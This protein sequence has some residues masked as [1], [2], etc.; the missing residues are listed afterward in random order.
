MNKYMIIGSLICLY[1]SAC[2]GMNDNIEEYLNRGEVNYLGKVEQVLTVG[3]NKRIKISWLVNTDP[4]I[5]SCKIFWNNWSDSLSYPIDRNQLDSGRFSVILDNINEGMYVFNIHHEGTKGYQ[6]I[7]QEV[8]GDV[9]GER[10]QTSLNPRR[11]KEIITLKGLVEIN[12]KNA[13]ESF[14]SRFYYTNNKGV[15]AVLDIPASEMKTIITDCQFGGT[16]TYTTFYL[17][18][19]QALDTFSVD[20]APMSF[21]DY[22]LLD[23]TNWKVIDF[24]D[25]SGD[26]GGHTTVIDG[27]L[28]TFWHNAYEPSIPPPHHI[29]L[30]MQEEKTLNKIV[31]ARRQNNSDLKKMHLDVSSD[32]EH[33]TTIGELNFSNMPN[34]NSM[35]L[36][37]KTGVK[38]RYLKAIITDSH[39]EPYVSISEIYVEG[40]E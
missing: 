37:L 20:A 18:K 16:F 32:N 23:R 17:P 28:T 4:R 9:Y 7:N 5:E 30:D 27:S 26:G 40:L 6:S 21:P 13:E 2:G 29:T 8:V 22:Y 34:Q 25:E 33:W 12:W 24:S 11:I 19:E 38:A 36:I 3:G 15:E 31:I 35:A 39:R 14:L 10:Y 1:L